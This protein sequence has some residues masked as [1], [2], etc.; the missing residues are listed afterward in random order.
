MVWRECNKMDEKLKFIARYLEGEKMAP[1]CR[2]FGITRPTGYKLIERYKMMGQ[3]SLVEQKRIPY[4][5]ANQLLISVEA[6]ILDLNREYPNWGAPKIREKII[7][8]WTLKEFGWKLV[9]NSLSD[10]R[11]E[12]QTPLLLEATTLKSTDAAY[13]LAPQHH[14][15]FLQVCR[16]AVYVS[17]F[18]D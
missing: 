16:P 3:C 8:R 1:L 9:L 4:R 13:R 17:T 7:N 6:L 11:G 14:R 12:D 2:E 18:L 15:T 10:F 5:Y